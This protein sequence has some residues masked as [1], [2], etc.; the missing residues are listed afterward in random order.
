MKNKISYIVLIICFISASISPVMASNEI[1]VYSMVCERTYLNAAD[2]IVEYLKSKQFDSIPIVL[3]HTSKC[4][5]TEWLLRMEII[6]KI[7]KKQ[8]VDS[9]IGEYL[10][11]EYYKKLYDRHL[12]SGFNDF[13]FH[14]SSDRKRFDYL[15]LR[16]QLDSLTK[17]ISV[18]LLVRNDL[19]ADERIICTLFAKNQE[20]FEEIILKNSI[21]ESKIVRFFDDLYLKWHPFGRG[22][23]GFGIFN[24]AGS[25][26][27]SPMVQSLM[28]N[29]GF[30]INEIYTVDFRLQYHYEYNNL[31]IH[32]KDKDSIIVSNNSNSLIF[33][34]IFGYKLYRDRYNTI[35]PALGIGF[36]TFTELNGNKN[37]LD[38]TAAFHSSLYLSY[39]RRLFKYKYIGVN[40]G[41]NYTA[42]ELQKNLY[43][44]PSG[45]SY[46]VQFFWSLL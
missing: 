5:R 19:S 39:T 16:H 46:S 36:H 37:I 43:T 15:P 38:K 23:V 18:Q 20:E 29:F 45:L 28:L 32:Y 27:I 26:K 33:Q 4:N 42:F 21:N 1:D 7:A 10:E 17:K 41:L 31:P 25:K 3:D 12:Y 40:F 2:L 24:P 22:Y 8:N 6:Y 30:N 35:A 13:G 9:I 44:K 11:Q 34:L 14:F